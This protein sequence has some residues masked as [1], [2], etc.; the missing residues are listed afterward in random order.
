M[1][2]RQVAATTARLPT[3]LRPMLAVAG[4]LPRGDDWAF[5]LKWD[6]VRALGFVEDG[7]TRLVSRSGRDLTDTYHELADVAP[8]DEST[9]LVDGEVVALDATGRPSF[10]AL[11]SRQAARRAGR[12]V[13]PIAYLVFDVM[14]IGSRSLLDQP[15]RE[16]RRALDALGMRHRLWSVPDA[17]GPPGEDVLA[18]SRERGLEGVVAKR[19]SSPY[20]AG[21]RSDAWVKVKNFRTQEVVIGGWTEGEGRRAKSFGSLLLGLPTDDPDRL[22]YVGNVGS[23]FSELGLQELLSRLV[24]LERP[25]SPFSGRLPTFRSRRARFVVPRLVGEVQFSEWTADGRLRQASWRGL[26]ADKRAE[27]VVRES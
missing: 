7:V 24:V 6:G 21:R 27:E 20:L 22:T 15:Y 8:L 11:Q 23:G 17:F 12:A 25:E 19:Q 1:S 10:Q 14:Q 9:A 3:S 5:E 16:R 4:A 18:A 13:P 2:A 26:R